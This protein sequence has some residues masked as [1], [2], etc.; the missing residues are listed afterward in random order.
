MSSNFCEMQNLASCQNT[1]DT[2]KE[3]NR[4]SKSYNTFSMNAY[5]AIIPDSEWQVEMTIRQ[6][7]LPVPDGFWLRY[8]YFR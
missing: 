6:A 3:L 4:L 5:D 2:L 7:S 8:P 1:I